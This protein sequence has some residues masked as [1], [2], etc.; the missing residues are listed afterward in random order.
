MPFPVTSQLSATK[1]GSVL[2]YPI[3]TSSP[4]SPGTQNT[5]ISLTNADNRLSVTVH[6]FFIDGSSCNVSDSFICLSKSQTASFSA[7]DFDPGTTGYLIAVATDDIGCPAAFN[8]LLGDAFVKFSSGHEANLSA[9]AFTALSRNPGNCDENSFLAELRFDGASYNMAPYVLAM[10]NIPSRLDGNDTLLV[11][12]RLGGNL[13][14]GV[15]ALG[16]IFGLFYDDAERGVSFS[17]N[18]NACQFRASITNT[19]PRITPRFETFV[20]QGRSGWFKVSQNGGVGI[21]GAVIN[22][23][24]SGGVNTNV[25]KGGHNLHK[26][27]LT[28]TTVFTIPVFPPSCG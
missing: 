18:H 25:F 26:L 10:D 8:A 12:D 1:L 4:T 28:N 5:R 3:Y 21:V 15:P 19:F 17:F 16:P 20:P 7:A 13:A 24:S 23:D 22:A 2:V 27:T 11:I 6:L 14:T 9:E